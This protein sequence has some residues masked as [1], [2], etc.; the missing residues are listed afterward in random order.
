MARLGNNTLSLELD[1][2]SLKCLLPKLNDPI[3][4]SLFF[5]NIH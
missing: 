5:K 1:F 4:K 2:S 3:F